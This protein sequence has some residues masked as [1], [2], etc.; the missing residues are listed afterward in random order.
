MEAQKCSEI[1]RS[2][3]LGTKTLMENVGLEAWESKNTTKQIGLEVRDREKVIEYAGLG[4]C[5]S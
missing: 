3:S 2:G 1:H 5:Q 4:G